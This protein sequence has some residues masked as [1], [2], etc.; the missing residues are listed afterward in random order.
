M[1]GRSKYTFCPRERRSQAV[2]RPTECI[3]MCARELSYR[4]FSR[5]G[6]SYRYRV[7]VKKQSGTAA[8]PLYGGVAFLFSADKALYAPRIRPFTMNHFQTEVELYETDDD[9]QH[10]FPQKRAL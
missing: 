4:K 10:A 5:Y 6:R 8:T 2:S 3:E 7:R 9:L 1:I